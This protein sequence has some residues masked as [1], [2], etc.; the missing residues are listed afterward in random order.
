M[1]VVIFAVL[2]MIITEP[3]LKFT[4]SAVRTKGIFSVYFIESWVQSDIKLN[5]ADELM[6]ADCAKI[7]KLKMLRSVSGAQSADTFVTIFKSNYSQGFEAELK[8]VSNW[9]RSR[10]WDKGMIITLTHRQGKGLRAETSTGAVL[11]IEG[12][13]FCKA[14]WGNYFG[15]NNVG[16]QVKRGLISRLKE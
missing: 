14:V 8:E 12:V 6:K 9:M 4:G 13:E 11:E 7:L 10:S 16:E 3:Q 15:R 5:T 2:N 1:I